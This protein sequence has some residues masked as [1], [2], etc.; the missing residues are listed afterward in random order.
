MSG[1][2]Q[3]TIRESSTGKVAIN[4][5]NV[6]LRLFECDL[7]GCHLVVA[8]RTPLKADDLDEH[9]RVLAAAMSIWLSTPVPS[10]TT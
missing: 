10:A 7:A 5:S 6:H 2:L 3:M 8:G 9:W 4:S 1:N